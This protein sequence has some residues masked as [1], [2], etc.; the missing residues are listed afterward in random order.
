MSLPEFTR[1]IGD[2][3]TARLAGSGLFAKEARAMV[4]TWQ[5]SYFQTEG[6]RVLFVLPQSWTDAFIPMNI[7]PQP[8]KIVRVMVGRLEMVSALRQRK[9]EAAIAGFASG[10]SSEIARAYRFLFDQGRYVEPII[11]HVART[12][13]DEKLKAFCGKLLL[14]DFV[15]DLRAAL[16][17]AS[18]GKPLG[19]DS[20]LLRAQQARLLRQ[21]GQDS[22]AR[23]ESSAVLKALGTLLSPGQRIEDSPVAVEIR[24]AA[25]EASGDDGQAALAYTRRV[26]LAGQSL[27]A[28]FVDSQ[29]PG[30]RDWWVGRAYAACTLRSSRLAEVE[31]SLRTQITRQA[32]TG[33]DRA[34][35]RTARMLL[36]FLLEAQGKESLAMAQ[37]QS[38]VTQPGPTAAS[39]PASEPAVSAKT[40][41]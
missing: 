34:A 30:M 29:V 39:A 4:N 23:S 7:D 20:L 2:D 11:R 38:M 9:A 25:L 8:R 32:K 36:A 14:T 37:W 16:H 3:L 17:N 18:D 21:V 31:S 40:G 26:E 12:T 6:V 15:T 5:S 24:A 10:N 28:E 41:I 13:K 27:A 22:Q 1:Q 33:T 35:D 19:P